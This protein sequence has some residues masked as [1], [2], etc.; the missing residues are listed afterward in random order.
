MSY[1]SLLRFSNFQLACLSQNPHNNRIVMCL[2]WH[3]YCVRFTAVICTVNKVKIVPNLNS[4]ELKSIICFRNLIWTKLF[5]LEVTVDTYWK[6]LVL[7]INYDHFQFFLTKNTE[8]LTV[9]D[10]QI[11]FT[12]SL[13]TSQDVR[14]SLFSY[15]PFKKVLLLYSVRKQTFSD[16][17]LK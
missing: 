3:F 6:E 8:L 16:P 12:L 1:F 10:Q 2:Q 15:L 14:C 5:A 17:L 11:Y 9:N 7:V 4:Y 13:I